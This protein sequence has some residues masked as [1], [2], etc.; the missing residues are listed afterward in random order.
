MKG[1]DFCGYIAFSVYLKLFL[2]ET[3][4]KYVLIFE[5]LS[6]VHQIQLVGKLA[7]L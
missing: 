1:F 7:L 4:V 2:K 6:A 5:Q 3:A